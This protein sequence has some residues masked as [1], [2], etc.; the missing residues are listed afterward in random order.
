MFNPVVAQTS[1]FTQLHVSPCAIDNLSGSLATLVH[2]AE[3]SLI[4]GRMRPTTLLGS[5]EVI[6]FLNSPSAIAVMLRVES[7]K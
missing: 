1:N 4:Q 7:R 3:L 2:L 5:D 6:A